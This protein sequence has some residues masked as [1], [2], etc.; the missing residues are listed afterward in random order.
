MTLCS[1][2]HWRIRLGAVLRLLLLLGFGAV[3]TSCSADSRRS[4]LESARA[5]FNPPPLPPDT[6]PEFLDY[7]ADL[8]VNLSDMAKLP[9]GVLWEDVVEGDGPEVAEGDSV[10]VGFQG[11]LPNGVKV[12]SAETTLRIGAGDV[13]AGIDAALPGMKPGGLRKLVLS[14]GLAYGA[15]GEGSIPPNAV[16]VYDVELRA[17]LP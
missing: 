2:G 15:D 11:W 3:C 16:L 10:V 17:K 6:V 7:A 12:D 4:A 13:L 5:V 8:Q 1:P 14:P 9:I